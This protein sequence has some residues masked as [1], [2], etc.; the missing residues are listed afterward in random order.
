MNEDKLKGVML[1][2][3]NFDQ[4]LM[5]AKDKDGKIHG[6]TKTE[7]LR[8]LFRVIGNIVAAES[9]KNQIPAQVKYEAIIFAI[10]SGL[11]MNNPEVYRS[12]SML[13]FFQEC[14][15]NDNFGIAVI[16]EQ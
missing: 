2:L 10:W 9:E 3:D 7:E 16:K 13:K 14:H 1:M 12:D 8:D 11:S 15:Q 4:I 5:F 6:I